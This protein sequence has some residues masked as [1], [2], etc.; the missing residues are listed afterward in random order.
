MLHFWTIP[1]PPSNLTVQ[2]ERTDDS[3]EFS[4]SS[5]TSKI[6]PAQQLLGH[7]SS[8]VLLLAR[9]FMRFWTLGVMVIFGFGILFL[10]FIL[11]MVLFGDVPFTVNDKP[12]PTKLAVATI[13]TSLTTCVVIGIVMFRVRRYMRSVLEILA[14]D[15]PARQ[16][17]SRIERSKIEAVREEMGRTASTTRFT[18]EDI[19]HNFV[20]SAGFL[21]AE[22][23]DESHAN[24]S[25]LALAGP[26][27]QQDA[28]WLEN[29]LRELLGVQGSKG[30]CI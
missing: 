4:K 15:A 24:V 28:Q 1:D 10:L 18:S 30:L 16:W 20:T 8:P 11:G 9:V 7:G 5:T 23:A 3:L 6:L 27:G 25:E 22:L 2:L 21:V 13:V 17:R 12:V 19:H 29:T 14:G 26:L